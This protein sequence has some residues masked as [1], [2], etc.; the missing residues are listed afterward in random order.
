MNP[1]PL[2]L[3]S[4]ITGTSFL[5][6]AFE[7]IPRLLLVLDDD[8][9]G[10]DDLADIIRIDAGLTANVLRLSN[11]AALGGS[12]RTKSLAEA[13]VRIGARAIYRSVLSL[14]TSPALASKNAF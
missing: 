12:R 6:P 4:L 13:I 14:I 11:S 1:A 7:L 2:D 9:A 3:E 10:S 5:P 8:A